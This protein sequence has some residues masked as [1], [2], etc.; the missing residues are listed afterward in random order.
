[1]KLF[2]CLAFGALLV[3]DQPRVVVIADAT[4]HEPVARASLY[5]KENGRFRSVISDAEGR[6][7]VGFDF[8]RLTVSH[9]N[10][11]KL[12]IRTLSDTIFL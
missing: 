1:M 12:T 10:Y 4:T 2:P 6:A 7:V 9:L 3:T 11:D 5:T 8:Q